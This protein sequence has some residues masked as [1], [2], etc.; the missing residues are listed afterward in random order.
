LSQGKIKKE[1]KRIITAISLGGY[2]FSSSNVIHDG[3]PIENALA[4]INIIKEFG[5]YL[6]NI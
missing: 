5:A 2:I 3:V 4:Y 1:V 6:I